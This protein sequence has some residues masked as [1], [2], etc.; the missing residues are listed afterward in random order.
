M[1]RHLHE[2]TG[3]DDLCLAG[4]VALNCVVN[5][6]IFDETPFRRSTSSPPPDD[7]GTSVGAAYHVW[8]HVLGRPAG[9]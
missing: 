3:S 5:G 8:H 9:S 6:K 1:L 4:G 2:R 7:G